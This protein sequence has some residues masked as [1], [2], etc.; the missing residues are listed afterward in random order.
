MIH[1][2]MKGII[3]F[4]IGLGLSTQTIAQTITGNKVR[5]QDNSAKTDDDWFDDDNKSNNSN[6]NIETKQISMSMPYS[7]QAIIITSQN[8][9]FEIKTHNENTVKITAKVYYKGENQLSDAEWFTK[10]NLSASQIGNK[11]KIKNNSIGNNAFNSGYANSYSYSGST[12]TSGA[13]VFNGEG[14]NRNETVNKSREVI[15]YVPEKAEVEINNKNA[16]LVIGNVNELQI[17]TTSG[18]LEMGSINKLTLSSKYSNV[19]LVKTNTAEIELL[20]GELT[21]GNAENLDLDTKYS[22]VEIDAVDNLTMTSNSDEYTIDQLGSLFGSK[23]YGS[24]KIEDLTK[25]LDLEG[26]NADLKIKTINPSTELVKLNNKYS[27]I[28][29]GVKSLANYAVNF[30]GVYTS[31]SG[32]FE[33]IAKKADKEK[34]NNSAK[35]DEDEFEETE[36]DLTKAGPAATRSIASMNGYVTYSCDNC[37]NHNDT[38]NNFEAK[39]GNV[40]GKHTKFLL[41]CNSG[42]VYFK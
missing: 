3:I 11:I 24:F 35:A 39:V 33:K 13:A 32:P 2:F 27:N 9:G 38:P 26:V 30:T 14:Q 16:N 22:V 29:F 1:L 6:K 10:I 23:N 36:V 19:S 8:R 18:H 40:T 31:V 21:I 25:K 7:N 34:A 4:L 15:I 37:N 20:N 17:E 28:K 41:K 12:T 42:Q 5:K